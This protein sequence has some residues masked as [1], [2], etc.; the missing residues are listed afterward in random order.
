MTPE[1]FAQLLHADVIVE[2]NAVYRNLFTTTT[3]ESA[4]TPYWKKAQALFDSLSSEQQETFFFVLRQI[5]VDTASHI[6]GVID[7]STSL[8]G[9]DGE[10]TLAFDESE[11]L[12]GYL[13][14]LF[15][16]IEEEVRDPEYDY[17]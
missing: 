2:N 10:L 3:V 17:L 1:H 5:G 7:G 6:L 9:L 11:V 15:L 13:Q 12:S 4:K 16:A 14:S 8:Q